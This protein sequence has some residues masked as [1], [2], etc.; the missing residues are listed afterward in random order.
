MVM[1]FLM[2]LITVKKRKKRKRKRKKNSPWFLLF[3][4]LLLNQSL[5]RDAT[6][7]TSQSLS[8]TQ[9]IFFSHFVHF[10]LGFRLAWWCFNDVWVKFHGSHV[11]SLTCLTLQSILEILPFLHKQIITQ[12]SFFSTKFAHYSRLLQGPMP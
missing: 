10:I 6:C 2:N 9:N 11:G 8:Q 4:S 1:I 7:L 3:K 5:F 12:F